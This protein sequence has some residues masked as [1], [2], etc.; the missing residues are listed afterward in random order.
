VRQ[1]VCPSLTHLSPSPFRSCRGD[2]IV[3]DGRKAILSGGIAAVRA[4]RAGTKTPGRNAGSIGALPA[5]RLTRRLAKRLCPAFV[6]SG[7]APCA[8][9]MVV[10]CR[11]ENGRRDGYRAGHSCKSRSDQDVVNA[12]SLVVRVP[13]SAAPAAIF[14]TAGRTQGL[15]VVDVVL[16]LV[17]CSSPVVIT[18]VVITAE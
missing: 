12:P 14:W 18:T 15:R 11:N 5:R 3:C 13:V 16:V 1:R 7:P 17:M 8:P 10:P 4:Q 2:T 9:A 6:T